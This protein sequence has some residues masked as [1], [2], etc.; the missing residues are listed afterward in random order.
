MAEI[1]K[2]IPR[3]P[4]HQGCFTFITD[5]DTKKVVVEPI[6]RMYTA[7]GHCVRIVFTPEGLKMSLPKEA[8]DDGDVILLPF[9]GELQFVGGI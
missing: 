6:G 4:D 5:F 1:L 8:V 9:E 3:L 7:H 2:N